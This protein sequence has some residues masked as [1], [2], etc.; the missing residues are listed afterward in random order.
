MATVAACCAAVI[1]VFLALFDPTEVAAP[2]CT[3]RLLT[4][5]DCPGCGTQRAIHA[6]LHGRVADAWGY[7]AALFVA[8]PLIIIY[9]WSPRRMERVLYAPATLWTIAAATAAWWVFRNLV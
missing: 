4:G 9:M 6:L 5:L 1:V 2:Q 8:V 7:N 3:F